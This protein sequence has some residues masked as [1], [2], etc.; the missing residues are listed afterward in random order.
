MAQT[1]ILTGAHIKLY[2]NNKVYNEVQGL[3]LSV[4]YGEA[5]IYGIDSPWPQEIATTKAMVRGSINGL[6]VKNSGG[7][8]GKNMRPLFTDIAA[9]PYISIRIQ[10]RQSGEDI[11]LITNAK[12]TR[13]SHTVGIKSTYK[14]NLEFIGQIILFAL[15][16]A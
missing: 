11:A 8:Q 1:L 10:D 12:V 13:E 9:S 14:L 5:E 3:N 16:R 7:L 15:D 4:D 2:I 6:R